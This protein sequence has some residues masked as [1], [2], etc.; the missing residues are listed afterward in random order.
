MLHVTLNPIAIFQLKLNKD[1][2][3]TCQVVAVSMGFQ[4]LSSETQSHHKSVIHHTQ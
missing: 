3:L 2:P 1:R 4:R